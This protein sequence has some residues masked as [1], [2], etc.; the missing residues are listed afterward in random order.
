MKV[1]QL[2]TKRQYRGAEVFAANLSKELVKEGVEIVFAG[3]Y[4]PG[5]NPL[6]VEGAKNVDLNGK[7]AFL[8][9]GTLQKLKKL[10]EAEKPDILQANGS[11]TLKYAVALR[12]FFPA[13]PIVYRNISIISTWI[14]RSRLKKLFY[15]QVFSRVNHVSSVGQEAIDD[16]ISLFSFPPEKTS[17]IRRGIPMG[18]YA[19][20]GARQSLLSTFGLPDTSKI[21]MHVG[22]FSPEKNHSFLLEVFDRVRKSDET[23]KLILIGD[24]PLYSPIK[25]EAISRGLASTV[26]FLGFRKDVQSYL[27]AA[28]LFVMGSTVEGVPGVVL[29]AATQFVPTVAVDVGGMKEVIVPDETGVLLRGHDPEAFAASIIELIRDEGKRARFGQKAHQMV[30]AHFD[31]EKN[32][33]KFIGL[34]TSLAAKK[35][36]SRLQVSS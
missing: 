35:A 15:K 14:G 27:A 16:L 8:S 20:E 33:S 30:S 5:Q 13:L 28:D 36:E 22:N 19:R 4:E 2:V 7:P 17:V 32:C 12:M 10:V 3:L 34:Y 29:E 26:F 24:G 18:V 25:Q 11:D 23:I 6:G 21:I 31:P 9:W 1:L